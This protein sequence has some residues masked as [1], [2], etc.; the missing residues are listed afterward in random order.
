MDFMQKICVNGDLR[1]NWICMNGDLRR[2]WVYMN[3]DKLLSDK[4]EAN[5]GYVY[6]SV[7]ALFSII[8]IK[9]CG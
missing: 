8:H 6:E 3:G 7:E 2:K 4:L 9:K 1:R 5:L